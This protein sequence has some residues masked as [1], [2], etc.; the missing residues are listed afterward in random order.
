MKRLARVYKG[1]QN[2]VKNNSPILLKHAV[3]L[4]HRWE[5]SENRSLLRRVFL[6]WKLCA[7]QLAWMCF[8][9]N[10]SIESTW[11]WRN[12]AS[13][14]RLLSCP[15]FQQSQFTN[16]TRAPGGW[17]TPSNGFAFTI[18]TI[19]TE[20]V[21]WKDRLFYSVSNPQWSRV[22]FFIKGCSVRCTEGV[23]RL[24]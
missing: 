14:P 20:A 4:L 10:S 9:F 7:W 5:M 23:I 22:F 16:K 1:V 17:G 13:L 8:F 24:S 18:T 15:R 19:I 6:G 12:G 21:V 3:R 2:Q 11:R